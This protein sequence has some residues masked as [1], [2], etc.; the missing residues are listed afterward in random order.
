MRTLV[1]LLGLASAAPATAQVYRDLTYAQDGLRAA[2]ARAARAR[3]VT[4]T[5][6]LAVMQATARTQQTLSDIASARITPPV[7]AAPLDPKA[8]PPALDLSQLVEIPDAA[9]AASN[10]QA[11]A[12]ADNRR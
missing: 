9:L 12:A 8:L 11:R 6:D 1:I 5:N 2:D 10:A 3:D 4:L 7:V